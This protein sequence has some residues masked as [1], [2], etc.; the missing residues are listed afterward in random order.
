MCQRCILIP[1][2]G[3]ERGSG[4]LPAA[5]VLDS[6]VPFV[7]R[8]SGVCCGSTSIAQTNRKVKKR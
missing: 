2:A 4:I 5:I 1:L 7:V 8:L 6:T 3:A